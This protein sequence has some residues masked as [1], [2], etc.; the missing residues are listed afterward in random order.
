M[1]MMNLMRHLSDFYKS[2]ISKNYCI[3]IRNGV[4]CIQVEQS[5]EISP[6]MVDSE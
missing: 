2:P 1:K 3:I 6:K 4:K 5:G